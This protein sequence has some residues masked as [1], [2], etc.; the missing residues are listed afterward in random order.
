M[1][2]HP[3][4]PPMHTV[5]SSQLHSVGYN[6]ETQQLHIAFKP[7]QYKTYVYDNVPPDVHQNLMGAESHGKYFGANIKGKFNFVTRQS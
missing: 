5:K 4:H 3:S 6:P 7:S 1:Q 2:Q